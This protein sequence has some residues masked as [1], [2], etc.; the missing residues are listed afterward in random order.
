MREASGW[1]E[2]ADVAPATPTQVVE[3]EALLAERA[4]C[5]ARRGAERAERAARWAAAGWTADGSYMVAGAWVLYGCRLGKVVRTQGSQDYYSIAPG[6]L[7][8]IYEILYADSGLQTDGWM[9]LN[10]D[11]ILYAASPA[12]VAEGEAMLADVSSRGVVSKGSFVLDLAPLLRQR[13]LRP[14]R[15]VSGLCLP[16]GFSRPRSAY[17]TTLLLTC[18]THSPV[19]QTLRSRHEAY[20]WWRY[21]AIRPLLAVLC[22]AALG[23]LKCRVV[24]YCELLLFFV[25]F[26]LSLVILLGNG[27]DSGIVVLH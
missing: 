12:Q 4:E 8:T 10:D 15:S 14:A 22:D 24:A 11:E 7:A 25:S 5:A 23:W 19:K 17:F 6:A 16:G 27:V 26:S 18:R 13:C 1:L 3:G 21:G 20:R 2:P 9:D